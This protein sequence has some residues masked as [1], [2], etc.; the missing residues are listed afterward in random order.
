MEIFESVVMEELEADGD[1]LEWWK[2]HERH[3]P[4]LSKVAKEVLGIPCSSAKSERVF[5]T[6][7]F[8]VTKKRSSL[9]AARVE[10]LLVIKENKKLVDEMQTKNNKK[11]ELN[12]DDAFK[13]A[14]VVTDEGPGVSPP[15]SQLFGDDGES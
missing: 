9:G 14:V 11:V 12:V 15:K 2:E 10:S 3:L 6:G 7:G 13:A 8:M 1:R 5:S 4:L